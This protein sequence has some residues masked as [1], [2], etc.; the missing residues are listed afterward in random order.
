[1]NFEQFKK[2]WKDAMVYIPA[3]FDSFEDFMHDQYVIYKEKDNEARC[4]YEI[5]TVKQW[6]DFFY[7][8]WDLDT[9]QAMIKSK[10]IRSRHVKGLLD[11]INRRNNNH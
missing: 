7:M 2:E 1:M 10:A 5:Y 8:D 3:K 11:I 9:H 4:F 6:C